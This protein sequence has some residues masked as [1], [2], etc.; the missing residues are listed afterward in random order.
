M[1]N[2][3]LKRCYLGIFI[4]VLFLILSG[5]ALYIVGQESF[6]RNIGLFH[7]A[8]EN[9]GHYQVGAM[10]R[11]RFGMHVMRMTGLLLTPLD[12]SF[13][14]VFLLGYYI[15]YAN[16]FIKKGSLGILWIL[17][18]LLCDTR[19][20]LVGT[21]AGLLALWWI[22]Q[23][24]YFKVVSF[25]GIIIGVPIIGLAAF[26]LGMFNSWME[27]SA[28]FHL[29]DLLVRG[30]MLVAQNWAGAGIGMTSAGSNVATAP[31]GFVGT[32]ESFYYSMSIEIGVIGLMS[33]F[34]TIIAI[35]NELCKDRDL[36]RPQSREFAKRIDVA[37]FLIV[38]LHISVIFLPVLESKA[39]SSM[40][41]SMIALASNTRN[42]LLFAR[43]K[44]IV[45]TQTPYQIR[46]TLICT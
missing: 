14:L 34:L 43:N 2:T 16:N 31:E 27:P 38:A 6:L 13:M 35:V 30:P 11:I 3:V 17:T 5:I 46:K 15:I 29:N 7:F 39:I 25:A 19:S 33:Y 45:E 26:Y 21:F 32:V 36:L 37:F 10:Y 23:K 44:D 28:L 8:E 1:S 42:N 4:W 22:N 24:G 9:W 12:M 40:M 18:Y 41:W 20:P